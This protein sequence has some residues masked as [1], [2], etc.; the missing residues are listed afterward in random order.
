MF[1]FLPFDSWRAWIRT[2]GSAHWVDQCDGRELA[3]TIVASMTTAHP[4]SPSLGLGLTGLSSQVCWQKTSRMSLQSCGGPPSPTGRRVTGFRVWQGL[5]VTRGFSH[6]S[7]WYWV[8]RNVDSYLWGFP[9]QES[10]DLMRD[11]YDQVLV[12]SAWLPPGPV[13]EL[14]KLLI[15][16]LATR[17]QHCSAISRNKPRVSPMSPHFGSTL[18]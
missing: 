18:P 3:L 2:Y 17:W 14:Q 12:H 6:Y 11:F 4:D 8:I 16:I 9:L 10:V 1:V 15:S 13:R 5:I 7:P